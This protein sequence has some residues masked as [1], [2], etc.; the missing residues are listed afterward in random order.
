MITQTKTCSNC[1]A[2]VRESD[3]F[4]RAC[5][6]HA[7]KKAASTQPQAKAQAHGDDSICDTIERVK[8]A[9]VKI[10]CSYGSGGC[11]GTGFFLVENGKTYLVTNYHVIANVVKEGGMTS[12][13]FPEYLNP[14]DDA[15]IT[16]VIGADPIN[17]LALLDIPFRI[18]KQTNR[19]ELADLDTLK[20][21]Q[22]VIAVGNPQGMLFNSIE[23]SIANT[24]L[25]EHDIQMSRIL[26]NLS[27]G[28]GN[29]GGPVVRA[30]DEKVI[31]V[32]TAIFHPLYLQSH[33]ICA[34]ADAIRQLI[35]LYERGN[36]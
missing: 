36:D 33:T 17:D 25:K 3:V 27:A 7:F 34:S 2:P 31:G 35:Y 18:P 32:A 28:P 24:K 26:C 15:Y 11:S 1:G 16:T 6:A 30:S 29:S 4:C 5:G 20:Q 13:S 21:G 22:K 10:I 14:R 9:T 12:V 23:G 19:L 8:Y